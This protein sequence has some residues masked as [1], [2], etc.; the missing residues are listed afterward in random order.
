MAFFSTFNTDEA[1]TTNFFLTF[2][3]VVNHE[4][5]TF[6]LLNFCHLRY[7]DH[8]VHPHDLFHDGIKETLNIIREGY[9]WLCTELF[10]EEEH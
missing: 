3:C 10:V 5:L 8:A 9:T 2:G 4:T 1:K 6:P 7:K